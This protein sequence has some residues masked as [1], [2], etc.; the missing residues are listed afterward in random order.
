MT[1]SV[2]GEGK[3]TTALALAINFAQ[4]GKRVLL[5]DADMRNPSM[6]KLLGMAND[7]GLSN[8]LSGEGARES[9]IRAMFSAQSAGDDRRPHAAEPGGLADGPEAVAPAGQGRGNGF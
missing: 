3:S 7:S 9:L 8:Y 4:L 6:H 2:A 1:S 5:V